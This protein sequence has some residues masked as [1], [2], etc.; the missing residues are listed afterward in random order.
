MQ[1]TSF[2]LPQPRLLPLRR[3]WLRSDK[4]DTTETAP[5]NADS[6]PVRL[7]V[8][9][10]SVRQLRLLGKKKKNKISKFFPKI[11]KRNVV[12]YIGPNVVPDVVRN[13]GVGYVCGM[14]G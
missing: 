11:T 7:R 4:P 12:L 13:V 2:L 5:Q 8:C 9:D 1:L 3:A 10:R 14:S 6:A